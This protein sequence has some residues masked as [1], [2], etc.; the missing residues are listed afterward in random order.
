M[1]KHRSAAVLAA[2]LVYAPPTAAETPILGPDA[3][4]CVAGG[5]PAILV[6]ITGLKNRLGTLRVRTFGGD[7]STW[8]DKV[9]WQTKV[10]IPTPRTEPIRVCMP[11]AAPGNYAID[12]RH[13][14]NANDQTDRSDGG[15]ASG[16]PRV[17][18]WDFIF[19]R[20]PSPK[21]TAVHVGQGVT[22]ISVTM[23]Y[24]SGTSLKPLSEIG[25]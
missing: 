9:K 8:F 3:A 6:S 17:T 21:Q 23:M 24:L 5:G 14:A 11:V 25:R 22:E 16:N 10:E 18:I 19:G 12:V 1:M 7:T 2:I 20:K 4:R 15:G 13:D